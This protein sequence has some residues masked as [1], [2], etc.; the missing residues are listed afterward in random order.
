MKGVKGNKDLMRVVLLGCLM[1]LDF[2]ISWYG[3]NILGV[4][5]EVNPLVEK[6]IYYSLPRALAIRLV[7]TIIALIMLY[8][9]LKLSKE[10]W[11]LLAYRVC[12]VCDIGINVWHLVWISMYLKGGIG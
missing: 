3:V 5:Y 2:V 6:I 10:P 9:G 7:Y 8:I 1:A 12:L 4:V 11:V